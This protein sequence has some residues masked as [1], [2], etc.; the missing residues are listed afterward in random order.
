MPIHVRELTPPEI[1]AALPLVRQ[2][3]PERTIEDLENSLPHM[4]Q[5]GFRCAGAFLDEASECVAVAGIWIGYR[6]WCGKYIDIDN[7]VV[8]E[9]HRSRGIGAELI[10]WTEDLGRS[11][12]CRISV[13]D[14]YTHNRA[15]HRLYH[16]L[17][18]EIYGFHF[19]KKYGQNS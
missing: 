3:N 8:A 17:G 9:S 7:I 11:E 12:G 2:L 19:V 6:F 18:Y 15:S 14:A 13:L 16:R 4:I 10:R 1:E 5:A